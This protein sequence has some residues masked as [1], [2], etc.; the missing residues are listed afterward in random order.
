MAPELENMSAMALLM[1]ALAGE[2]DRG[3]TSKSDAAAVVAFF[4]DGFMLAL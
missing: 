3:K 2:I 4:A 1:F